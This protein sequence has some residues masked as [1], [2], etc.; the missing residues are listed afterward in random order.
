MPA[1]VTAPTAE[2]ASRQRSIDK[3]VAGAFMLARLAYA[4]GD[5]ESIDVANVVMRECGYPQVFGPVA[6]H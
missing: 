2:R 3:N 6:G 4:A 5:Q 1:L